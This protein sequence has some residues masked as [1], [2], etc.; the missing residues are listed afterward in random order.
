V[1]PLKWDATAVTFIPPFEPKFPLT[2]YC[3]PAGSVNCLPKPTKN[4]PEGYFFDS[5]TGDFI[6]TPTKCDEVAITCLDILDYRKDTLGKYVI[7]GKARREIEWVVKDNCEYNNGPTISGPTNNQVCE[8]DKI[9]FMIEAKDE[10]FTPYQTVPDTVLLTWSKV[11]PECTFTIVNPKDREKSAEFCWQTR[12]G[13]A[14]AVSYTFTATATDQHC[15]YPAIA[16]KGFKIKVYQKPSMKRSYWCTD[17]GDL[18]FNGVVPSGFEGTPLFRWSLRDSTGNNEYYYS[19]KNMDTLH[20]GFNK[21]VLMV[22]TINNQYNCPTI[23]RDTIL[24]F[25]VTNKIKRINHKMI[26]V[27]P[28]PVVSGG[29]VQVPLIERTNVEVLDMSGRLLSVLRAEKDQV[30]IPELRQGVYILRFCNEKNEFQ[31][32]IVVI[33]R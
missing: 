22:A 10:T 2:P 1:S 7:V 27:F 28:N 25:D 32:K 8:G 14:S 26:G 3:F 30:R 9:C 5:V 4:P 15:L 12:I 13:Q 20:I 23:Y 33:N 24:C 6:F 18:V 31:S 11:T 16:I 21:R 19:A 17:S 29:I